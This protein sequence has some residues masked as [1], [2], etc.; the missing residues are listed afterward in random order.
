[1]FASN[2]RNWLRWAILL[3]TLTG[4]QG[5][6]GT[7]GPPRDPLFVSKTP[8]SARA[9]FA[10]PVTFAYLEPAVPRDPFSVKNDPLLADKNSR[11]VPGTLTNRAKE[12]E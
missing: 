10:P 11:P 6:F 1:M 12:R 2:W 3:P 8:M 4:C 7:Q 5:F 9:E